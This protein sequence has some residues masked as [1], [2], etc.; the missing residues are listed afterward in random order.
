M[1]FL[2]NR[3]D[4]DGTIQGL[5]EQFGVPYTGSGIPA[6]ALAMNREATK[7]RWRTRGLSTPDLMMLHAG[8]DW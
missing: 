8:A 7:R 1:I 2:H 6:S 5:L 4:E 3:F